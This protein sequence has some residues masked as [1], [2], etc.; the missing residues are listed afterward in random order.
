MYA[1]QDGYAGKQGLE[2]AFILDQEVGALVLVVG[3]R[4]VC[5]LGD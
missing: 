4:D 5:P 1:W 3:R 2:V